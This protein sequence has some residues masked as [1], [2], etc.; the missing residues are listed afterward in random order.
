METTFE[1]QIVYDAFARFGFPVLRIDRF[2]RGDYAELRM[3]LAY[4]DYLSVA[5]L[6]DIVQRLQLLQTKENIEIRIVNIDLVHRSMRVNIST[7]ALYEEDEAET[8]QDL[9]NDN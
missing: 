1:P 9:K 3:E 6:H 8:T 2:D 5:E 4:P 7:R